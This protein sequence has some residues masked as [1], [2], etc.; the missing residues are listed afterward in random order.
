MKVYLYVSSIFDLHR[1]LATQIFDAVPSAKERLFQVFLAILQVHLPL[2]ANL[3]NL[4][5]SSTSE[6]SASCIVTVFRQDRCCRYHLLS[7]LSCTF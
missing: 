5:N 7:V 4:M 2:Q 6:A 1:S 3:L